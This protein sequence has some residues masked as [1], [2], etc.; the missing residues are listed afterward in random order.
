[1]LFAIL[2]NVDAV[3]TFLVLIFFNCM[4]KIKNNDC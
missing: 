4:C 2:E 3:F 1:M